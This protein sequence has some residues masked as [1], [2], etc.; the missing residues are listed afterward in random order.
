[1]ITLYFHLKRQWMIPFFFFVLLV[2]FMAN[3]KLEASDMQ[4]QCP[5]YTISRAVVHR[6]SS[7]L[8]RERFNKL[9]EGIVV[10]L[11]RPT[12]L[13][14]LADEYESVLG[15]SDN[16]LQLSGAKH[17]TI[18]SVGPLLD[19]PDKI[20]IRN[21]TCA[22]GL[23]E[24]DVVYTKVRTLG[25][26]LRRNIRWRPLVETTFQLKPVNLQVRIIWNAVRSM[27]DMK[28]LDV[29]QIRHEA[30]YIVIQ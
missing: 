5:E 21:I 23:I 6:P 17:V 14:L 25:V 18:L 7:A 28:P 9:K 24:L 13:N 30:S 1:V 4:W 20:S 26:H 3:N 2:N 29:Q 8:E 27:T 10:V 16:I 12:S 19:S 22:K 15:K 11:E